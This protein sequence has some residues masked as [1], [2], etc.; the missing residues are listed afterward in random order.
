MKPILGKFSHFATILERKVEC[1]VGEK[2]EK[3]KGK[4]IL[5]RN[6]K[7]KTSSHLRFFG[8]TEISGCLILNYILNQNQWLSAKSNTHPKVSVVNPPNSIW[9]N[10]LIVL[11][12]QGQQSNQYPL[13]RGN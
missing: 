11:Q 6:Q 4:L 2:K 12:C 13:P 7:P 10:S 8:V 9:H 3:E 1:H 5:K